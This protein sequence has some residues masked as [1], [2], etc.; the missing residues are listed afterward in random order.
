MQS[1]LRIRYSKFKLSDTITLVLFNRGFNE[2]NFFRGYQPS[3]YALHGTF[4]I[5]F[6][7]LGTTLGYGDL[8]V[9]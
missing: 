7:L 3:Y 1:R 6:F 2:F 8:T 9:L 5:S 4:R